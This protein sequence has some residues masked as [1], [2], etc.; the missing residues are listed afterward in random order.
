MQTNY[1]TYQFNN[2]LEWLCI[3]HLPNVSNA[4]T[5]HAAELRALI[6]ELG[7]Y[8]RIERQ[9]R[10]NSLYQQQNMALLALIA[11]CYAKAASFHHCFAPVSSVTDL[12]INWLLSPYEANNC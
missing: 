9:V 8:S 4:Q 10:V 6:V 11:L 1:M 2:C 3:Q 7:S 12:I 5:A